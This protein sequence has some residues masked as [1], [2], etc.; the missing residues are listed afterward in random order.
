MI[1]MF[2]CRMCDEIT[3]I[4]HHNDKFIQNANGALS[5][6]VVNSVSGKKLK[7]IWLVCG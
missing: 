2:T 3:L 7:H 5:M 4:L 1:F 6:S